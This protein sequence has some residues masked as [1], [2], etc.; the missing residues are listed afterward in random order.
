M[1]VRDLVGK[2]FENINVKKVDLHDRMN[3]AKR[4]NRS[5]SH[6]KHMIEVRAYKQLIK[7]V[8]LGRAFRS[9]NPQHTAEGTSVS[10]WSVYDYY[11][12]E[13]KLYG[14]YYVKDTPANASAIKFFHGLQSRRAYLKDSMDKLKRS[15]KGMRSAITR[16]DRKER[17]G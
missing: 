9:D 10:I 15:M 11:H 17:W 5:L 12:D 7:M 3:I 14:T 8:E 6:Q 2:D 16:K 13:H 1:K 4:K